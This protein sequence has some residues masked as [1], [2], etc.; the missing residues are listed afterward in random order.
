MKETKF[1]LK[2]SSQRPCSTPGLRRNISLSICNQSQQTVFIY[3]NNFHKTVVSFLIINIFLLALSY[4]TVY[5]PSP[6]SC[7]TLMGFY[8]AKIFT[9]I[10]YPKYCQ[11]TKLKI[12]KN[13]R[14]P[15]LEELILFNVFTKSFSE[16]C[17]DFLIIL[18]R[19]F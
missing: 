8:I 4:I 2:T 1:Y 13:L 10:M 18:T 9:M 7:T 11:T 16:E 3:N 14:P 12:F 5:K 17:T 15:V 6:F 19:S